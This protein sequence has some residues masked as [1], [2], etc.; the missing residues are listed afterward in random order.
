MAGLLWGQEPTDQEQ[1]GEITAEFK[2]DKT[3]TFLEGEAQVNYRDRT[4]IT[5]KLALNHQKIWLRSYP[6]KANKLEF[7]LGPLKKKLSPGRYQISFIYYPSKQRKPLRDQG[8]VDKKVHELSYNLDNSDLVS[9]RKENLM[10]YEDNLKEIKELKELLKAAAQQAMGR[11]P[12]FFLLD[13][14]RFL[15]NDWRSFIDLD[16]Q[17]VLAQKKKL[18]E[19]KQEEVEALVYQRLHD[20][21]YQLATTLEHLGMVYSVTIYRY[22]HLPINPK[23][24]IPDYPLPNNPRMFNNQSHQQTCHGYLSLLTIYLSC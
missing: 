11:D 20:Q 15:V 22:Y 12:R 10:A 6:V 23:D 5:I 13:E 19:K 21:V 16:F 1:W 17:L 9:I 8:Q 3:G 2:T 24:T 14:S 7:T 18:L 4:L